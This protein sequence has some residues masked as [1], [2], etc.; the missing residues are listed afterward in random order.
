MAKVT[1][2]FSEAE[3][4]EAI[5]DDEYPVVI[6]EAVLRESNS[7][8]YPYINLT[9][10]ISEGEYEGRKQWAMLSLHPKALFR[11]KENFEALGIVDDPIE[12]DVDEDDNSVLEP[13]LVG[14][15]A[16]F[17]VSTETQERGRNKGKL[18][19]RVDAILPID[20]PAPK[21][22][23]KKKATAKKPAGG[24]KTSGRKFS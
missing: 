2:D 17:V 8:E 1:V 15:P 9:G 22:D 18:V 20:G 10:E 5:P 11:T 24:K 14:L 12:L 23:D 7:S 21:K 4:F 19:N 16:I 13:E 6:T 3:S